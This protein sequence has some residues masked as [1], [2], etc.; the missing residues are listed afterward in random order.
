MSSENLRT[1]DKKIHE[2]FITKINKREKNMKV[3]DFIIVRGQQG[4]ED[5]KE[6]NP[7]ETKIENNKVQNI[8]DRFDKNK[9]RF[10]LKSILYASTV[11]NNTEEIF[12]QKAGLSGVK[13]ALIN[14]KYKQIIG[15]I[16]LNEIKNWSKIKKTSRWVNVTF[17][18][19][20]DNRNTSHPSFNFTTNNKED[21]LNFT[22]KLV[23]TE[24][25]LIEFS[26]GEKNFQYFILS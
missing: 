9:I 20:T 8:F 11:K 25:N 17:Q 7:I 19:Q 13:Y 1:K 4:L 24:N 23:D 26:D 14:D 18:E 21:L 2:I 5:G 6:I 15:V 16:N 10:K 12:L 3:L 22:L